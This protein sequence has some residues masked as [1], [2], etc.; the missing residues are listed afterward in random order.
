MP[1]PAEILAGLTEIANRWKSLA[2]AWPVYF[3]DFFHSRGERK[4]DPM[5]AKRQIESVSN[6][7]A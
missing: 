3:A 2:I 6:P 4:D 7:V 5:A 1:E